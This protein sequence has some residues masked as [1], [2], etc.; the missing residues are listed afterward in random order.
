MESLAYAFIKVVIGIIVITIILSFIFYI[1]CTA[2]IQRISTDIDVDNLYEKI[3]AGDILIVRMTSLPERILTTVISDIS[4]YTLVVKLPDDNNKYILHTKNLGI[5]PLLHPELAHNVEIHGRKNNYQLVELREYLSYIQHKDKYIV[6]LKTHN[7]HDYTINIKELYKLKCW[8][9][10]TRRNCGYLTLNYLKN[11]GW[12]KQEQSFSKDRAY[13]C[14]S[15][16]R[17]RLLRD[18]NYTYEGIYKLC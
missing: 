14:P 5:K 9:G 1:L 18:D 12:S 6:H 16:I 13:Y 4:H 3:D 8:K 11:Q 17:L 15:A 7:K 2:E 10:Y